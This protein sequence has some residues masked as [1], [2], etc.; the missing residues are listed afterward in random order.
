M[1]LRVSRVV[2]YIICAN[3]QLSNV[4]FIDSLK[5]TNKKFGW[6]LRMLHGAYEFHGQRKHYF[7]I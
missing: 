4:L 6:L 1:L 7:L 5:I 2:V 3:I